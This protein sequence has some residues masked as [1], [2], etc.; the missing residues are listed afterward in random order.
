[1]AG[2]ITLSGRRETRTA[3][4]VAVE[5]ARW[6]QGVV[7][8]ERTVT[9]NVSAH[10]ARITS[11]VRWNRDEKV[12]IALRTGRMQVFARV[13]YCEALPGSVFA[14]GVQFILPSAEWWKSSPAA[15]K[16]SVRP[17]RTRAARSW[18]DSA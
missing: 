8:P 3:A 14:A 1:M 7:P 13:V 5:I 9:E 15:G 2:E 4:K 10:G 11:R 16:E 12:V 17:E 6:R 18:G